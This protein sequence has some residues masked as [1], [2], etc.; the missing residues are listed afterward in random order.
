MWWLSDEASSNVG[1]EAWE[2]L[3]EVYRRRIEVEHVFGLIRKQWRVATRYDKLDV[4]LPL[5]VDS[6]FIID[7]LNDFVLV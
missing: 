3:E 6:A 4:T 5:F 2:N 7:V 1:K